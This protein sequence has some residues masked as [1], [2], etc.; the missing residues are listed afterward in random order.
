[1]L[2][3]RQKVQITLTSSAIDALKVSLRDSEAELVFWLASETQNKTSVKSA[4]FFYFSIKY[5]NKLL[6]TYLQQVSLIYFPQIVVSQHLEK[7]VVLYCSSLALA[8]TL[9]DF[10]LSH[11]NL[12][13]VL[14]Q[15]L[16]WIEAVE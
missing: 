10:A 11:Q 7:T 4:Q 5:L 2:Y 1:M 3:V 8:L 12:K 6:T 9:K 13:L 14:L 15:L 16:A